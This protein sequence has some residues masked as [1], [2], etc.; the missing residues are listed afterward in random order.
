MQNIDLIIEKFR[1]ENTE[2]R[3]YLFLEFRELRPV[4][5]Q[6]ERQENSK[7]TEIKLIKNEVENYTS[8]HKR[9]I[10]WLFLF[11]NIHPL[12]KQG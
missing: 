11:L 2:D 4:F 1:K 7:V 3:L 12:Q 8:L 9:L 6:I 5:E 10:H